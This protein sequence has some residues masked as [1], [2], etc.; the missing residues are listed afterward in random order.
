M[1]E[2][3]TK[4]EKR[5]TTPLPGVQVLYKTPQRMAKSVS[6]RAVL[7]LVV[8]VIVFLVVVVAVVGV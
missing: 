7:A 5:K 1:L 4:L 8:K 6:K 3:A 2:T